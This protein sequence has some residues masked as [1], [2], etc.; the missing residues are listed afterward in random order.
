MA[1]LQVHIAVARRHL[2]E[3]VALHTAAG[4]LGAA[5]RTSVT[6]ADIDRYELQRDQAADRME[7]A[8]AA[9]RGSN[10]DGAVR[11]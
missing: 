9:H 4:R 11:G 8:F 7:R 5:A 10:P 6:L 2:D 3:A 1:W